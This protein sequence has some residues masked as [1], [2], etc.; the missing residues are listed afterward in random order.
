MIKR[1][2]LLGLIVLLSLG[3]VGLVV[4]QKFFSG[5]AAAALKIET[6]PRATVFIDGSQVGVTPFVK[7]NLQAGEHVIKIVPE[8]S[9]SDFVVWEKRI[10]LTSLAR[11]M[12]NHRF[13]K[14][15]SRES[16]QV[17][18]LEKIASR[19]TAA[20]SVISTPDQAVVKINNE[21]RGFTPLTLD[22]LTPATY[23]IVVSSPGYEE[24]VIGDAKLLAGYKLMIEVK[25]AQ[26]LDGFVEQSSLDEEEVLGQES[27]ASQSAD[28]KTNSDEPVDSSQT[29]QKPY[30]E[31]KET[32]T[33]WLRVRSE[34]STTASESGRAKPGET[35]PYLSEEE[36]G[37]YK[38]DFNGESGWISGDW[39]TLVN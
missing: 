30:V 6:E 33:G 20:L 27:Q 2:W 32:P 5:P 23:E 28:T 10:N 18:S 29:K 4:K 12:I 21:P 16:G 8:G 7:D 15:P 31:I 19:E 3:L 34:P 38:I 35:Y 36:N 26:E 14:D 1:N 22:N 25:L 37:W 13:A 11:T 9:E 39:A 17:V 24:R